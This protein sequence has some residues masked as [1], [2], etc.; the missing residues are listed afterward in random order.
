MNVPI[1]II[2]YVYDKCLKIIIPNSELYSN[3]IQL[4]NTKLECI[5]Y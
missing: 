5:C 3:Y 4:F 2:T 1:L